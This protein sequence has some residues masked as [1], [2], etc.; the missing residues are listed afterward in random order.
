M[1]FGF[2]LKSPAVLA[3][4]KRVTLSKAFV[5]GICFQNKTVLLKNSLKNCCLMQSTL[6]IVL[7]IS[8]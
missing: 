2:N 6:L 4:N 8:G 7:S 5:K 1:S 3:P